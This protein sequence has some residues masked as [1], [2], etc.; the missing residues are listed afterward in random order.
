[1]NRESSGRPTGQ[2]ADGSF[3]LGI[4][5]TLPFDMAELW[6][7]AGPDSAM[8]KAP[9]GGS[10]LVTTLSEG[11]HFRMKWM[12]PRWISHS[13]LQVRVLPSR[14]PS[15]S[16]LAIHQEKLPDQASRA[17]LLAHWKSLV[18]EF[19]DGSKPGGVRGD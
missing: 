17:T 1:M 6:R 10:A 7:R 4:R 13:I 14:R 2:T 15:S 19:V 5:R 3:Q 12:D 9:E 18:D 16:V 8:W 11:N